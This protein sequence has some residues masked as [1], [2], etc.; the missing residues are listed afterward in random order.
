MT[1]RPDA[2][3]V[4]DLGADWAAAADQPPVVSRRWR[5]PAAAG[6]ALA[7]LLGTVAADVPAPG[8]R[9]LELARWQAPNAVVAVAGPDTVLVSARDEISAYDAA[10]GRP[11]WHTHG[12]AFNWTAAATDR[13]QL[14]AFT[15]PELVTDP[16]E[17][18]YSDVLAV[19][20]RSGAVLWRNTA[21]LEPV[22][23]V[24]VSRSGTAARP[25]VAVHDP[26]TFALRW[27]V[28]QAAAAAADPWGGALWR[29][30]DSGE[31]VEHD[32]ATGA[33]RRAVRLAGTPNEAAEVLPTRNAIGLT[34]YR[35]EGDEDPEPAE[36]RSWY[37]R[38]RLA[39]VPEEDRWTWE[40]ACGDGLLCAFPA[41]EG[42]AH[43]ID[44][45]TGAVV[46][47]LPGELY[48]TSPAGPL[49]LDR[50]DT[51]L[52][53]RLDPATG[54][55]VSDVAGWEPLAMRTIFVRFV[56][57]PDPKSRTT[58]LAELTPGGLRR[59]GRVP[60]VSLRCEALPGVLACTTVEGDVVIWRVREAL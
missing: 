59:L 8:P 1:A 33:V 50:R 49:V 22:G 10:D 2:P 44:A 34:G 7:A 11:L 20:R 41:R 46:R 25:N 40:T 57:R 24:L 47:Q 42:A 13:V 32:L 26:A 3:A 16:P 48:L 60:G 19:D 21:A 6:L 31:L 28:P 14:I 55:R 18:A 15:Q 51:G 45:V 39:P 30:T 9:L 56:A 58:Y 54:E 12:G 27:R 36:V 17:T 29:L 23:G 5:L 52:A 35:W 4:I 37:D 43:L 53:G 38:Q